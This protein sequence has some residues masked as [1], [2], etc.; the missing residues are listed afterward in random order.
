MLEILSSV[1]TEL[2]LTALAFSDAEHLLEW[3]TS[4]E[5]ILMATFW[6]KVLQCI[7]DVNKV[8]QYAD[9]SIADEVTHLSSLQTDTQTLRHSWN[10]ILHKAKLVASSLVQSNSLKEKR[11]RS[12]MAEE[13]FQINIF[14]KSLDSLLVQLSERFKAVDMIA[15]RFEFMINP[16]SDPSTETV[17]EQA[18][19]LTDCYPNGEIVKTKSSFKCNKSHLKRS[20]NDC[21]HKS[22]IV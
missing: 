15:R 19:C 17:Q 11:P 20:L 12:L 1:K 18:R 21:T 10:D 16:P 4:Y 22:A 9:I 6:F 5:Y 2:D 14:Y 7:D 13:H 8:L 3:M